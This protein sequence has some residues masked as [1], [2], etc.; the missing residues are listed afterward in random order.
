MTRIRKVGGKLNI[1]TKADHNIYASQGNIY[2]NASGINTMTG[3]DKGVDFGKPL[4]NHGSKDTDFDVQLEIERTPFV[5]FGIPSFE[6]DEENEGIKFKINVTGQGINHWELKIF[7]NDELFATFFSSCSEL[8]EI[9]LTFNSLDSKKKP[10]LNQ[11]S[12]N[13]NSSENQNSER[14]IPP[15]E[16][17]LIWNGENNNGIFDSSLFSDGSVF[18]AELTGQAN[19]RRRKSYIDK[20]SFERYN[21]NIPWTDIRVDYI[22]NFISITLKLSLKDGGA[23]GIYCW[24]EDVDP[25]PK[26]RVPV[27]KCPW[28]KIPNNEINPGKPII[29]SRIRSFDDMVILAQKGISYHW[30]RNR[31][32]SYAKN[33]KID[34]SEFEVFTNVQNLLESNGDNE[35]SAMDDV[36]LIFNTNNSWMR[37][38][39]PGTVEGVIS[40]IGN[41]VSREAICYNVGYIL[42]GNSQWAYQTDFDEDI[43]F[44]MTAAHEIGHTI[45]KAYGGTNYSYGH[46]GSVNVYTQNIKSTS[47]KI[48]KTG[49]VDIMPYYSDDMPLASY[50]RYAASEEDVL[51]IIWLN[52]LKIL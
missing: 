49:E 52:K 50:D 17:T 37:S 41:V 12:E 8:N 47:G 48:P 43:E 40:A 35:D 25:D 20:F 15:G 34:N 33:V 42:Y 36:S 21:P 51:G 46:K 7:R 45:L 28:D 18:S 30:G 14:F 24:E 38:G 13:N 26:F 23:K 16:Y 19:F 1:I 22:K 2:C 6:G 3:Q 5:P 39:N 4:K 27:Q 9:V 32:H 31:Y 11:I 44:K 10:S 29:K